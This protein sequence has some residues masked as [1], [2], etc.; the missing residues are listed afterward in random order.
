MEAPREAVVKVPLLNELPER[1]GLVKELDKLENVSVTEPDMGD[2]VVKVG[3]MISS[4][5]VDTSDLLSLPVPVKIEELSVKV[6]T[7]RLTVADEMMPEVQLRVEVWF[8]AKA[9]LVTLSVDDPEEER[10]IVKVE[11]EAVGRTGVT[12]AVPEIGAV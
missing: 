2:P 4:V 12:G 7:P 8:V 6:L 3:V 9:E 1:V 11:V 10:V 5:P